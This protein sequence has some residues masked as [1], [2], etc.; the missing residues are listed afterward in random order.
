[1][2]ASDLEHDPDYYS[3]DEE[4][5]D[6][7]EEVSYDPH[8]VS[9]ERTEWLSQYR[10]LGLNLGAIGAPKSVSTCIVKTEDVCL[11]GHSYRAFI[12]G[13]AYNN[14]YVSLTNPYSGFP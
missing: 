14:G 7:F 2:V 12:S 13:Q 3:D 4:I 5:E 11:L 6:Y 8:L 9:E 10:A 1:L